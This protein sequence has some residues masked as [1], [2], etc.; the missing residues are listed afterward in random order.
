[1]K[2]GRKFETLTKMSEKKFVFLWI[3]HSKTTVVSFEQRK[4]MENQRKV[5]LFLY[6]ETIR[7]RTATMCRSFLGEN[8]FPPVDNPVDKDDFV[9]PNR[10]SKQMQNKIQLNVC[11]LFFFFFFVSSLEKQKRSIFF[12]F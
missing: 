2:I 5:S 3:F 4:S 10:P 7:L 1:M 11:F 9:L 8:E 12:S 6:F